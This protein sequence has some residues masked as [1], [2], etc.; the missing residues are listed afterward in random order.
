MQTRRIFTLLEDVS[1]RRKGLRIWF[2]LVLTWSI[3]RSLLVARVFQ[4]YGLNPKIY[5]AIDFLSSIPYAYASAQ[6]LLKFLDKKRMRAI[7]WG[8][9]TISMFNAPDIYIVYISKKVPLSTY[10]GFVIILIALSI[11]AYVQWRDSR[12]FESE[13]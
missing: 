2:V 6:S 13:K 11:F 4:R 5:F 10:A 8:L 12:K 1:A 7:W 9:L 3:I